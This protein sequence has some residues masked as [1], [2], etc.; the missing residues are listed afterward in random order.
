MVIFLISDFVDHDVPED[1][2]YL[3]PR[4]DASVLHVYDPF[5]F[6]R[7]AS[8]AL[9]GASPEGDAGV[10]TIPPEGHTTLEETQNALALTC[11]RLAIPF[12]SIS[13]A[14]SVPGAL[15]QLFHRKRRRTVS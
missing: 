5:E 12:T 1:L 11:A 6:H 4:H 13:T 8:L 10:R 7:A 14:T 15:L 3:R 2:R 9:P